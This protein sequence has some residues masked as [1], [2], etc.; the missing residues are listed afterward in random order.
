MNHPDYKQRP[1]LGN[2][3]FAI[4]LQEIQIE[5]QKTTTA[6]FNNVHNSVCVLPNWRMKTKK[7]PSNIPENKSE[8][9]LCKHTPLDCLLHT[10]HHSLRSQLQVSL[11]IQL[12]ALAIVRLAFLHTNLTKQWT[13]YL[14]VHNIQADNPL[15]SVIPSFATTQ[16]RKGE[17]VI[18]YLKPSFWS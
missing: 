13:G 4:V 8:N 15:L 6:K 11:S 7:N 9:T 12:G 1:L 2:H 14:A 18:L 17:P 5:K 16:M 10:H 3:E